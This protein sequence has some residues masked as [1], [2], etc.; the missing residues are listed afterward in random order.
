M[1]KINEYILK[2]GLYIVSLKK[3]HYVT[4]S[5]E[6]HKKCDEL[7][8]DLN[9][10]LDEMAEM[11]YGYAGKPSYS[12]FKPLHNIQIKEYE[13]LGKTIES[14]SELVK[15]FKAELEKTAKVK[16]MADKCDDFI[17][18][19]AKEKFLLTFMKQ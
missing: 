6:V 3:I 4:P 9:G 11:L 17:H 10:F 18:A 13:T 19:L 5:M 12:E 7:S 14:L 15:E 8:E 1:D 2:F 16:Q